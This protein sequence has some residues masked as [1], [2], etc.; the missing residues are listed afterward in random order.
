M[1]CQCTPCE[2]AWL[3]GI[4]DGEG[5]IGTFKH[6]QVKNGKRY[7][8]WRP[9][10]QI[11]NTHP[12]IIERSKQILQRSGIPCHTQM[13]PH[14][15]PNWK[16]TINIQVVGLRQVAIAIPILRPYVYA[17]AANLTLLDRLVQSRLQVRVGSRLP[18]PGG[19][20]IYPVFTEAEL[21]LVYDLKR[22]T[23]VGPAI[24]G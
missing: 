16:R 24:E 10:I 4:I 22:L 23:A 15:N 14:R 6:V 3:G 17:K 20:S 5:H 2:L 11:T 12:L 1:Y 18:R 8:T 19:G 21:Q 13:R 9:T 7:E